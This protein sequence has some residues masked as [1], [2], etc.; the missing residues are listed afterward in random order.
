V[1][2]GVRSVYL[3]EV[4]LTL[5]KRSRGWATDKHHCSYFRLFPKWMRRFTLR[6][7]FPLDIEFRWRKSKGNEQCHRNPHSCE[8]SSRIA[9]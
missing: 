1:V 8:Y 3:Q 6:G 7:C 9:I 5:H 2:S 4:T